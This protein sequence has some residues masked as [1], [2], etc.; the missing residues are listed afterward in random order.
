MNAPAATPA[1]QISTNGITTPTKGGSASFS[2]HS[3][4]SM[5][6]ETYLSYNQLVS[7]PIMVEGLLAATTKPPST[8]NVT[9]SGSASRTSAPHVEWLVDKGQRLKTADG[10]TIGVWE[11]CHKDDAAVLSA[12]AKHFRNHYCSDDDIDFLRGNQSRKDYLETIK[13]PSST[14][15]LGPSVRA[16]DFGEILIAD[17]LQ[18]ILGYS[19][20]RVRWNAKIVRDESSK[21]SDVIGFYFHDETGTSAKDSLAVFESKTSFSAASTANRLQDAI[22]DSAKDHIRIDEPLNYIKQRLYEKG[23]KEQAK[24]VERFQNPVDNPYREVFG[25]AALYSSEHLDPSVVSAADTQKIPK[26]SKS[27]EFQPHPNSDDLV[28]VVIK[29][30][31]MMILVHELYRRAA[32]EA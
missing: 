25:A 15:K 3:H 17:Y 12:W 7:R 22:N 24:K 14:S 29:G 6:L 1:R 26:S 30:K 31:D 28:L 2:N 20:P 11:L 8:Q 23:D 9:D 18:W 5:Y 10:K 27:D 32:D 13:F 21:G 19:V 4:F 16:G